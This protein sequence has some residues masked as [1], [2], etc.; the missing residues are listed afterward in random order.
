MSDADGES[1]VHWWCS[2]FRGLCGR[3]AA[4]KPCRGVYQSVDRAALLS[5][6]HSG[7]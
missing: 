6:D 2:G 1:V 3:A 5:K 4:L 7:P